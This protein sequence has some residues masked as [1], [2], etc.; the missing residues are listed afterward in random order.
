MA[1]FEYL[2]M[3]GLINLIEKT[4]IQGLGYEFVL[5]KIFSLFLIH[6]TY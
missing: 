2:L 6:A 3:I 1:R 5:P 4:N